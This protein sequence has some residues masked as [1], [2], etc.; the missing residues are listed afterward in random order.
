MME[1]EDQ[2]QI[3]KPDRKIMFNYIKIVFLNLIVMS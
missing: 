3:D 1:W 2:D